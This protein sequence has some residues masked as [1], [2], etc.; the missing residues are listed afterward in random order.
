MRVGVRGL[1]IRQRLVGRWEVGRW[2]EFGDSGVGEGRRGVV[3]MLPGRGEVGEARVPIAAPV[4]AILEEETEARLVRN[5][6]TANRRRRRAEPGAPRAQPPSRP[7]SSPR[8]CPRDG[9]PP[10]AMRPG[11]VLVNRESAWKRKRARHLGRRALEARR[12]SS[13][14]PDARGPPERRVGAPGRGGGG[15]AAPPVQRA[16]AHQPAHVR[17][18]RGK[19]AGRRRA[20]IRRAAREVHISP[21][22]GIPFPRPQDTALRG[23][24]PWRGRHPSRGATPGGT[25]SR[26]TPQPELPS[27]LACPDPVRIGSEAPNLPGHGPRPHKP[28]HRA[29]IRNPGTGQLCVLTSPCPTGDVRLNS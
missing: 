1:G 22:R 29:N 3:E 9:G 6:A 19:S 15:P 24:T 25:R 28:R 4:L 27:L 23:D 7:G 12:R 5:P 10:A 16:L 18:A 8:A 2:L 13:G 20:R 14:R 11:D 26:R 17:G 21:P